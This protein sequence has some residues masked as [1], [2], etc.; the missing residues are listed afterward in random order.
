MYCRADGHAGVV[1][2]GRERELLDERAVLRLGLAHALLAL[3]ALGDV[4]QRDGEEERA[5]DVDAGD[6]DL[7]R[8]RAVVGAKRGDLEARAE[9]RAGAGLEHLGELVAVLGRDDEL[10]EA[11]ADSVGA[12]P[13]EGLLG[14][15]V[16]LGDEAFVVDDHDAVER[17]A[18]HGVLAPLARERARARSA[19]A[20]SRRSSARSRR[21]RRRARRG[22]GRPRC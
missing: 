2:V 4:A 11:L 16:D 6:R 18:Q 8:E 15:R 20:R 22:S 1:D 9:Q 3:A 13:A 7:G 12:R 14:R 17:G 5:G 21:S 10:E 19:C